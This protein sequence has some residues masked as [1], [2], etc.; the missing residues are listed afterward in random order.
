MIF[1][2]V[3]EEHVIF[4]VAGIIANMAKMHRL[5]VPGVSG[6][7]TRQLLYVF[8]TLEMSDEFGTYF[9]SVIAY[10]ANAFTVHLHSRS[11][12]HM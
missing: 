5:T 2:L 4:V 9:E 6:H 10:V 7:Y 11:S 1:T 12:S 3:M 8:F